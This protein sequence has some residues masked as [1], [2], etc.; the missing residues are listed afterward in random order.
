MIVVQRCECALCHL[1]V[2]LKFTILTIFMLC[3][4]HHNMYNSLSGFGVIGAKHHKEMN[5]SV[6]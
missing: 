1:I 3:I 5:L 6:N 4:F 2:H